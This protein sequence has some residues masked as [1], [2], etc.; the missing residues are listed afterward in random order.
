[1]QCLTRILLMDDLLCLKV[2]RGES[3]IDTH[4][5]YSKRDYDPDHM[6][7]FTIRAF[8]FFSMKA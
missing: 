8:R 7:V 2:F 4:S 1:M 5:V 6:M 3:S